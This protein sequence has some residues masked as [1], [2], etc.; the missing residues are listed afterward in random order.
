VP[1]FPDGFL[2]GA[3]TSAYQIEG[4]RD[5]DGRG[6]S[7]WDRFA[8]GPGHI[9]DG[10]TGAIACDHYHRWHT[11]VEL[12]KWLGLGAYR[13]SIAWPRI[14]PT[15]R[16][17][18]NPPGLAFYDRLVDGLLAAGIEPVVTLYHWDLPQ[19][20]EDAG[21]WAVRPVVDAYLELVAAVTDRLGDR[22]HRWITHNEPWCVSAL[23]YGDGIHAPGRRD[24]PAA[25]A[26]AHHLLL[27]HGL[28]IPIIRANSP[29]AQVGI[30]LNLVPGEPASSSEADREAH[31]V[32]DGFMNRWYLDPLYGRGYPA[33]AIADHVALGRL[34]SLDLPFYRSG[35]KALIATP[36]DF[37]GI[38]YYSRAVLR[39]N[40][41]PEADN[42]PRTVFVSNDKT[43]FGWEVYPDGLRALLTRVHR[44]YAPGKLYITENG[45]A[46]A[47]SPDAHGRVQDHDRQRYLHGHLTA[48]LSAIQA[49]VPL[50]GYFVWSLIDNYE[51]QE[52]YRKRFGIVWVD[53]ATQQRIAKESA[54]YY[55]AAIA[56]NAV[57]ALEP[58]RRVQL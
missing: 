4:A 40:R 31:R 55:R 47:A 1:R 13:F 26:A 25:L 5:L 11:D 14:L 22:V 37:L 57:P 2:W 17:R 54:Y 23:G 7:I 41:V 32:F 49:G 20:L 46:Y 35:D 38:N 10:S 30:T 16:G 58:Q 15:G 28:A 19:A 42:A 50:A 51:W 3:A 45:A 27:S 18:V 53:F 33:D 44:D 43:D 34:P 9:V 29:G 56:A 8:A 48:C 12:M 6:E 52:G 39:S 36:T 21:G 24:W